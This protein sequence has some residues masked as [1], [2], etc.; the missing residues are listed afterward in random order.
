VLGMRSTLRI[1]VLV[2]VFVLAV[3]NAGEARRAEASSAFAHATAKTV[4]PISAI[5]VNGHILCIS[6]REN[7]GIISRHLL[8]STGSDTGILSCSPVDPPHLIGWKSLSR[9]N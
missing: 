3:D 7:G 6:A 5:C 8:R 2:A 4:T 1:Q 9:N